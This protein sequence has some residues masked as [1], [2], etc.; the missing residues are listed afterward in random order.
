MNSE[1]PLRKSSLSKLAEKVGNYQ[2]GKHPFE[3][4][5]AEGLIEELEK[6]NKNSRL[7]CAFE[8]GTDIGGFNIAAYKI[9]L[10]G[11][12]LGIFGMRSYFFMLPENLRTDEGSIVSRFNE[13]VYHGEIPGY[14]KGEIV[15][16]AGEC[17][18]TPKSD[19]LFDMAEKAV[20]VR[21]LFQKAAEKNLPELVEGIIRNN[22]PE[23]EPLYRQDFHKV[24]FAR[25]EADGFE[26]WK[27]FSKAR[28]EGYLSKA[29]NAVR[30]I[31][32][33]FKNER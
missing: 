5:C 29:R 18:Q 7:S 13:M 33:L 32:R 14:A 23:G 17:A 1:N 3:L 21:E 15:L 19:P 31:C 9:F 8:S 28:G 2:E 16:V 6:R 24:K 10:D 30:Y 12:P 26:R 22:T 4:D 11:K 25:L 20:S 27:H